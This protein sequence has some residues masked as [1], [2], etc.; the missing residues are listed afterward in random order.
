M[1]PIEFIENGETA[2]E[3]I[4]FEPIPKN[5]DFNTSISS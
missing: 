3:T 1:I 2:S 5:L 4:D